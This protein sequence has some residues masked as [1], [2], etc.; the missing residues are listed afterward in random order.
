MPDGFAAAGEY[1]HAVRT[2]KAAL[3]RDALLVLPDAVAWPEPGRDV[4]AT[5]GFIDVEVIGDGDT[6]V[7]VGRSDGLSAA[8]PP[9][10]PLFRP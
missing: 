4:L 9:P 6:R 3:A 10:P 2:V 1:R 5:E 7:L 8:T